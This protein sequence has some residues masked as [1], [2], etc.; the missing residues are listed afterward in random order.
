MPEGLILYF[1]FEQFQDGI[2]QEISG[3][4][5]SGTLKGGAEISSELTPYSDGHAL[6]VANADDGMEINSFKEL[7]EYQNNTYLWW[8]YFLEESSDWNQIIAKVAPGSDR[9]PGIW[10]H[11]E[12]T[13]IH[14]RL[15]PSSQGAWRI[16]LDGENSNVPLGQWHHI[17]GVKDGKKLI[18]YINGEKKGEVEVNEEMSQGEGNLYIGRSSWKAASFVMDDLVVFN[19]ALDQSEI[20]QIMQRT[21]L[22]SVSLSI[23]IPDQPQAI[24]DV[25]S[26]S[27]DGFSSVK[28][29]N[30]LFSISFDPN[31]LQA[32]DLRYGQF[33]SAGEKNAVTC[34]TPEID[35]Q[36]GTIK[37]V[38][39]QRNDETETPGQ[40]TLAIV[41]FLALN[42]G[43]SSLSLDTVQFTQANSDSVEFSVDDKNLIVFPKHSA[44]GGKITNSNGKSVSRIQVEAYLNQEIVGIPIKTNYSGE[45]IIDNIPHTGIVEVKASKPGVLP[46]PT[47]KVQVEIGTETTGIDFTITET[48]PFHSVT[49]YRGFIRNWLVLGLID[50]EEEATRLMSDQ[51]NPGVKPKAKLPVQE[52]DFKELNPQDGDFGTGLAKN[53]RWRLYVDPQHDDHQRKDQWIRFNDIYRY[54]ERGVAYA[55]TRVKAP[56]DMKV[57][58]QTDH[59]GGVTIWLNSELV[60]LETDHIGWFPDQTDEVE[61]LELKEGWNTILIKT[62]GWE[63]SCRFVKKDSLLSQ[64]EPLTNLEISP[65][66]KTMSIEEPTGLT[67]G[68]FDLELEKGLN[69]ISLPV[70]P[71][72][73]MTAKTLA[74]EIDAT[75]VI[76][77]DPKNKS[78]VPFVP[79]HFESSNFQIEG[80]MGVIVNVRQQQTATFTGTVWDNTATAP[81]AQQPVWA[82][83][84]VFDSLPVDSTLKVKNL[85]SGELLHSSSGMPAIA[86][87]D[88][89][90]QSVVK[91]QDWIEI[92]VEDRRWRYQ[93]TAG[94][95]HQAFALVP[96]DD[97]I[98]I[99][100]QTRLLQ[101]Y[102]NPFNPETWLPFEL[103]QDT[104]VIVSIY[105]VQGKR[106]RQ[107]Q[108]GMM[109]A[110]KYVGADRAVHWDGK[111]ES[112][113]AVA[114]GTYFYQINAVDYRA[115]RKMVILK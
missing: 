90:Q 111:T 28:L 11:T 79:E 17:T 10:T 82:F 86:F 114:S 8:I 34:Q 39:C 18:I 44:V 73:P 51:L 85:R 110:G 5:H 57:T 29:N 36:V 106:V 102:P 78:F 72:R 38:N 107:L 35:N 9:S 77:L 49:D 100:H 27:I 50:W 65:Q 104:E 113:E 67:R 94:D 1:D 81:A 96:L 93:L 32:Q 2:V 23:H 13:G 40:G 30:F 16:G 21:W 69:M 92:E 37:N 97:R 62:D 76:R 60:H 66:A 7:S 25:F 99:P 71:D 47:T 56:Q 87:V 112:G 15:N 61:G 95:L 63:L 105:D 103:S 3:N 83:G 14:Y 59:G 6:V 109:V 55:F 42:P 48:T 70:R 108:L 68:T 43:I 54:R 74:Q 52:T 115:T 12:G 46:I 84:L 24:G 98:R 33:I 45:Y 58:L 22:K 41:E 53:F 101:N 89:S 88:Q 20:I 31:L 26:V 80:G 4:K 19:R 64:G 75:L 91:L